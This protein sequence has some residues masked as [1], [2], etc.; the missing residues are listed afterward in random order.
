MKRKENLSKA[1]YLS[2][3]SKV[4]KDDQM[5]LERKNDIER[6]AEVCPLLPIHCREYNFRPK[7]SHIIT[8]SSI[9]STQEE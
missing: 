2:W 5:E 7:H 9:E 1:K 3:I 6:I 4:S 8:A